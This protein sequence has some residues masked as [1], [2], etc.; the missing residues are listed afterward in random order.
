[1]KLAISNIAW[2]PEED[3]EVGVYL[4]SRG[5]DAVELAP[6]KYWPAPESP[7]ESAIAEVRR[8]WEDRGQRVVALQSLLFGMPAASVF[9]G[10]AG[11]QAA[12]DTVRRMVHIGAGLGAKALV[13]GS[14]RNRD[15]GQRS[16]ADA[17]SEAAQFF[18]PLANEAFD[19]GC[20]IAFEPNPAGY[21][22][23]FCNT[24]NE[25]LLLI[26]AVDHPGFALHVDLG[27][28]HMNREPPRESLAAALPRLAHVHISEPQLALIG[29]GGV[30]HGGMARQLREAG[31]QGY[32]SIEMRAG[33]AGESNLSRVRTAIEVAR[34]AYVAPAGSAHA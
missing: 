15:R 18:R 6:T 7:R 21:H 17:I 12:A 30:D 20:V 11:G 10:G 29:T 32:V 28:L 25:A 24:V 33:A 26:G 8:R 3:D 19:A 9:G 31:W 2:A 13:F 22:C 4:A 16:F 5:V 34:E 14:P 23:N 1:M 27:I